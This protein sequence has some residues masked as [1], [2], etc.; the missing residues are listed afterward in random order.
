MTT[1]HMIRFV[2]D[3]QGWAAESQDV[4]YQCD[5]QT[6]PPHPHAWESWR[7]LCCAHVP[8]VHVMQPIPGQLQ[9][10]LYLVWMD[11]R[12]GCARFYGHLLTL[13][14]WVHVIFGQ[15]VYI[16]FFENFVLDST[17]GAVPDVRAGMHQQELLLSFEFCAVPQASPR[18][19]VRA[20]A[21]RKGNAASS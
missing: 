4:Q 12:R 1:T 2:A 21:V 17:L 18:G 3:R 10:E 16:I 13:L 20:P 15:R 7:S 8:W 14:G 19:V 11:E 5:I 9:F 6:P